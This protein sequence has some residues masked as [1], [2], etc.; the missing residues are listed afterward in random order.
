MVFKKIKN[1]RSFVLEMLAIFIGISASFWVANYRT[2]LEE[3]ELAEKYLKGFIKDFQADI[4][5]LDTLINARKKQSLSAKALLKTIET[6]DLDVDEFYDNY[7]YLY[8]FYRFTPSTNTLE[9]VL[10]TSHLRLINDVE[11]KN[12]ILDL[13]SLHSNIKLVE[14]HI[15]HD[16]MAYLYNELTMSNIEFNGLAIFND[17]GS[18]AASKDAAVF[19]KDAENFM[20]DRYFK[21]FW[22]LFELNLSFLLPRLEG[23]KA[24]SEALIKEM[25]S[26]LDQ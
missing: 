25:K 10:N 18:Y 3:T 17:Q 8:P 23:A 1:Y 15:Y 14:E 9:E 16:R 20:K 4:G 22:N 13:R 19:K 5:Q 2:S 21:S 26:Q 24:E 7:F 12:R 11:L 6:N